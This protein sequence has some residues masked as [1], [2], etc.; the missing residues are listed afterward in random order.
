MSNRNIR[1]DNYELF[2]ISMVPDKSNI[3][4]DLAIMVVA[5]ELMI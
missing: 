2:K 3:R 1:K 5:G 4:N